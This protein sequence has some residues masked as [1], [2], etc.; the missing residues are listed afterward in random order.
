MSRPLEWMKFNVAH[1][2]AEVEGLSL[3]EQGA[4]FVLIRQ[5]WVLGPLSDQQVRRYVR[6]NFDAVRDRMVERDGLLTFAWLEKARETGQR[7]QDQRSEAGRIS[8]TKRNDRST[9]V[10]RSSNDRSTDVLSVSMSESNSQSMSSSNSSVT[11]AKKVEPDLCAPEAYADEWN[12][13]LAHRRDIRKPMT[14]RAQRA[15]MDSFT[16]WEV[17]RIKAAIRHS[18]A[19]GWRGIFEPKHNGHGQ[20]SNNGRQFT[21]EERQ[22]AV[23]E[24]V[25]KHHSQRSDGGGGMWGT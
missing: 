23:I 13:W 22:R 20:D 12:E 15:L 11:R 17:D 21:H 10:K 25:A 6:G 1:V 4:Y 7:A 19:N 3:E 8:A 18:I 9:T 24:A 5:L 14:L 2:T 16:G